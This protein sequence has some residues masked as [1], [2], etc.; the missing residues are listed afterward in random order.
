M[1]LYVNGD[2]HSAGAE[3]VN[4]Y[5]FAGDDPEIPNSD[6]RPHPEN[7][8]VSYG[9]KLANS[10]GMDFVTDAESASSNERIIRTTRDYLKSNRPNLIIIG[11]ATWE[12]EEFLIDDKYYQFSAGM[13]DL[14]FEWSEDVISIYKEWVIRADPHKRVAFWHDTIYA[15]H[16][17]LEQLNI[18]HIFFN[19]FH[20]FNHSFIDQVDWNDSYIGPYDHNL[21][22]YHWLEAQGYIPVNNSYHYGP[23]AH[24]AWANYLLT[25]L[26]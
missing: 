10:L 25:T 2:S 4:P 23:D 1:I 18:P 15:F 19:T 20:A 8:V 16:L 3:A 5:C 13:Y 7:I 26:A 24:T 22:Y 12:R 6:R 17:E 9:Y 11:W 14:H 21:T